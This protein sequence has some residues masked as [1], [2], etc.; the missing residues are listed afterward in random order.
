MIKTSLTMM[1]AFILA[2]IAVIALAVLVFVPIGSETYDRVRED[3]DPFFAT[4]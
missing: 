4:R 2:V 3:V 1:L